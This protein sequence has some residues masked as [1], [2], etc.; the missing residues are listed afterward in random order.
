[1]SRLGMISIGQYV[2]GQS[3]VHR[4]D[5]RTKLVAV[6]LVVVT[7]FA[8]SQGLSY[9]LASVFVLGTVFLSRIPWTFIWRGLKPV[10]II[11]AVTYIFHIWF[12]REGEVLWTLGALSV[13]EG[14]VIQG[15]VITY[16][17]VLLVI[18]ASLVTLTTPPLVLTN[19][20]ERM[21]KPLAKWRFPAHELALMVAIALRFI[22]VL[23]QEA[24]KI[25]KAQ[26]SRG[27]P[28]ASGTLWERVSALI[29]IIIP[30]FL[31]AFKRAEDL[32]LAMEARGYRGAEGRTQFRQ[33]KMQ[34]RDYAALAVTGTYCLLLIMIEVV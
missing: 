17:I 6:F 12:T 25:I 2:P 16:R 4:L 13:Y 7:I 26:L 23:W 27:A 19:G 5:P 28:L 33:L 10:W 34:P 31:S 15:A 11:L 1:M 30:L 21:L 18:I 20:L 8:A 32:A 9:A 3:L 14:G 22:P 29:P 24:D